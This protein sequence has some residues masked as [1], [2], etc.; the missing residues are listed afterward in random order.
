MLTLPLAVKRRWP[1]EPKTTM[2]H[3]QTLIGLGACASAVNWS[4]DYIVPQEAWDACERG[5][6]M[7]WLLGKL[8]GPVDSESRRKLVF[9]AAQCAKEALPIFEKRYPDDKR[10]RECIEACEAYSRGE[11]TMTVLLRKR[12]YAY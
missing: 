7:L 1:Q 8:S 12:A 4:R 10:V 5:D 2:K 11:I 3:I 9:V 6:W